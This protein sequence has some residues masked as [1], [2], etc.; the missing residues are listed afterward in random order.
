MA[1]FDPTMF[2]MLARGMASGQPQGGLL[3]FLRDPS[4]LGAMAPSAGF[5]DQLPPNAQPTQGQ[6]NLTPDRMVPVGD[7]QMPQFGNPM[8]QQP[9]QIAPQAPAQ[10]QGPDVGDRFGA[11]FQGF[12]SGGRTGGLFGALAG[13]AQGF[14]TG[15]TPA[16]MTQRALV[17]RGFD[18]Q[19]AKVV[20]SDPGLLRAVLPQ[21]MG[22]SGQTDD[23][24]EYQFAKKEE[25]NLTFQQFMQRKRAVSGEYSLTPQYGT[26]EKGETVLL[27]TGKSGEAIETK[28][29]PG[30]KVSSGVD[31]LDGG[32]NWILIDKRTGNVV[33]T[34]PKD[35]R[36]AEREKA[37]GD[38]Q[39]QAQAKIPAALI[40]A[41]STSKKIDELLA[42]KDGLD[43]IVG[44][45][46]QYRPSW[47]L[48]DSGRNA[49]A[50]LEQLQGG[51]F[52]QAF[53]T[54]KGGGAI[55]EAE[56]RKAEQAIA[57]MQR[58][59]GEADFRIALQDF[60][61]AVNDGIK[62]LRAS[63]GESGNY[64]PAIMNMQSGGGGGDLKN[65]YGLD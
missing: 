23:I 30:V 24:K 10:A 14:N 16:N 8:P 48:G 35:L 11:G 32:T 61:D 52:L 1:I 18:P 57:R 60:R 5:G 36:G 6:M 20:A 27:Q 42:T 26:N 38:A 54:L 21:I 47:T 43:S 40:D 65:K 55:T 56:G 51:A 9:M 31:K 29:P 46:D 12:A 2:N 58:S 49:L 33:G 44:P 7:Y 45:L 59:Q 53:N 50:R 34:Q 22:T 19:L 62:K 25:P 64:P 37:V 4:R 3:D 63:A 17:Q 28:L 15:E 41:E 13:A 39:G